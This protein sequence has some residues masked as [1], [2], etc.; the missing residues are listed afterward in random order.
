VLDGV[1]L[2]VPPAL[3]VGLVGPNGAG[4]T[5]LLRVVA[6]LLR[7]EAGTVWVE[8][9]QPHA[10]PAA[11]MARLV[12]VLPQHPVL[13]AGVSVR[14]AVGWGRLPHLGRFSRPGHEDL[15][16]VDDALAR[17]DVTA[18]ADRDTG[19][20]SGGERQRVL[21]AR[22]LAQT[23]RVLLLD[24]P[25]AHLDLGHQVE[26]MRMLQGLARDGLAIVAA[27]HDLTL[28]AGYCDH[29]VVL[30]AGRLL[31][32]GVPAYVVTEEVVAAAY[33]PAAGERW[34]HL[35]VAPPA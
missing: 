19:A 25:T 4:K 16:A 6:G 20:L 8:G 29:V 7:P 26:I 21:I 22:A 33:G 5:T 17:T 18:L 15:R 31:A 14:E 9:R 23:P 11:E 3:L 30:G 27:L 2:L 1:T 10:T 12:A 24:E 13:P 35:R 34:R 28:A 32:S